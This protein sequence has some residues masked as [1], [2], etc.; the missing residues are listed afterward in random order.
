VSPKCLRTAA[1][2]APIAL[3]RS[4]DEDNG[5]YNVSRCW[6]SK[7]SGTER[8][9]TLIYDRGMVR[10]PGKLANTPL[11]IEADIFAPYYGISWDLE[12][13]LSR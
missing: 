9:T 10:V 8:V 11:S 12:P 5:R 7:E 1:G 3:Q 4:T 2:I 13:V 6:A